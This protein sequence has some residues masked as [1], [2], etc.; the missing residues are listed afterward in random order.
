MA[1]PQ[2]KTEGT[3]FGAMPLNQATRRTPW[4]RLVGP[5]GLRWPATDPAVANRIAVTQRGGSV[6]T[7]IMKLSLAFLMAVILVGLLPVVALAQDGRE[8]TKGQVTAFTPSKASQAWT[9]AD[10]ANARPMPMPTPS[11]P[12]LAREEGGVFLESMGTPGFAPGG[13]GNGEMNPIRLPGST[14]VDDQLDV[15][16]QEYGTA[17]HPYTTS[18]VDVASGIP[19]R[20]YPFRAAGKLYFRIGTGNYVCSA[21]L[22][23]RGVIVTAAHCVTAFGGGWYNSW[24]FVPA[25]NTPTQPYGAWTGAQAWVMTSYKNGTDSCAPGAR[26]VVCRNDVAVVRLTAKSGAY[27]GTSTGWYGY[28]WNGWGF[29]GGITLINQLGYP[30]SHDGGNRMQRTDS[31]GFNSSSMVNNTVW[32]GRQTGGSSGGPELNNLGNAASLAGTGYGSAASWNIV[33]GVTSWGYTSTAVKQ[34]GASAFT[35]SNI[36]VLVS[37]VCSGYTTTACRP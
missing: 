28:G 7:R 17:R 24:V 13:R 26:G 5:P 6:R 32:G 36:P 16:P 15:D 9:A 18:R 37:S 19:S 30:V 35:S 14:Y 23:K 2:T 12:A 4:V 31:E 22:I 1:M 11:E 20:Y 27:P 33:V 8:V 34:Q 10:F 25:W 29:V 3:G 21:S